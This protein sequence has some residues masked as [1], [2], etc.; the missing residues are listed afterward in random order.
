MVQPSLLK[1]VHHIHLV[2]RLLLMPVNI[3]VED[4]HQQLWQIF[5]QHLDSISCL[6]HFGLSYLLIYHMDADVF[7]EGFDVVGADGLAEMLLVR[8]GVV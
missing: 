3:L 2:Q 5:I 6:N 8:V 4:S 7:G 1:R